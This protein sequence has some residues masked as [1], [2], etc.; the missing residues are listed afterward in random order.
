MPGKR[1]KL[2]MTATA[3]VFLL[4][5]PAEAEPLLCRQL[6]SEYLSVARVASTSSGDVA[7]MRRELDQTKRQANRLG[8]GG[9]LF[10]FGRRPSGQCPAIMR[11]MSQLQR[12]ISRSGGGWGFFSQSRS[13]ASYQRARLRDTLVRNGCQVPMPGFG[14]S[15]YRTVCVRTCDGYY[16][17]IS[18][19]TN[20]SRFKIDEAVC[21]SMY[22]GQ[23]AEL[24]FYPS[25]SDPTQAVSLKNKPYSTE[26]FAFTYR[27]SFNPVC[28]AQLKSGL[29]TLAK[30]LPKPVVVASGKKRGRAVVAMVPPI[31]RPRPIAED[32]ETLANFAG[33]LSIEMPQSEIEV[34]G[35]D[36]RAIRTIGPA[37]YYEPPVQIDFTRRPWT[38]DLSPP[39]LS[40]IG[41]AY[42]DEAPARRSEARPPRDE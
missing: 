20:S 36:A 40:F 32:P 3:A 27:S 34:A 25:G 38:P 41:S 23:A 16:F 26:P 29:A 5:L 17:P 9:G 6:Q 19:A 4:S 10:F 11:K 8:C 13:Q 7:Q 39:D 15:G 14:G 30:V 1:V 24:Y 37:Y 2:G 12:D 21:K 18:F 22:M 42:A 33:G 35:L 28:A 31:P